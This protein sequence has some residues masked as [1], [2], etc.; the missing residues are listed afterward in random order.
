MFSACQRDFTFI[1]LWDLNNYI[2]TDEVQTDR[3]LDSYKAR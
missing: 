1:F 3:Q 2:Y